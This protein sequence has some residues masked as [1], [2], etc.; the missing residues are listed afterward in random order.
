[1]LRCTMPKC[2]ATI[3]A[4]TGLQELD[5]LQR[6]FAKAHKLPLTMTEALEVRINLE[7]GK[8]PNLIRAMLG[9]DRIERKA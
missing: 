7:D 4:M 1:M 8:E 9:T 6:H 2:R 3:N 5:K